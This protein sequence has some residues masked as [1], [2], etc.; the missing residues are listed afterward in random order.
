MNLEFDDHI[1]ERVLKVIDIQEAGKFGLIISVP[2]FLIFG[3]LFYIFNSD[4]LYSLFHIPFSFWSFLLKGFLGLIV[5]I[6]GIVLHELIHGITWAIFLKDGFKSIKFGIIKEHLT[7]YCHSKRPMKIK[8]YILGG[9]MPSILL[10]IVPAVMG[11]VF[12]NIWVTLFGI[13]FTIASIGDFMVVQLLI[14]ENMNDYAQDHPSE[15][16]CYVYRRRVNVN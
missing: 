13:L 5:Y 16:G 2:V 3:G 11:I 10:G 1:Y 14:E 4:T 6:M 9:I 8:H 15:A 12:G 7:P